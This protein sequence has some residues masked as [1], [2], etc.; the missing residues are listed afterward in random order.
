MY[1][2]YFKHTHIANDVKGIDMSD[3]FQVLM[4]IIVLSAIIVS[5]LY[6]YQIHL[7]NKQPKAE[8]NSQKSKEP[9]VLP[10][11]CKTECS[12]TK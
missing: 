7:S 4:W 6:G 8:T 10:T 3:V 11:E 12:L 9:T 2:V 1:K 5:I